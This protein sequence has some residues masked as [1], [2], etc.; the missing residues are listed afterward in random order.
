M[1]RTEGGASLNRA[2]VKL[3]RRGV[4]PEGDGPRDN[5]VGSSLDHMI[6]TWSDAEADEFERALRHFETIDEAMWDAIGILRP[7]TRNH[8][9]QLK[10]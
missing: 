9:G 4:G 10:D 6:G 7:N 5:T 3:L 2:A 8:I 1:R